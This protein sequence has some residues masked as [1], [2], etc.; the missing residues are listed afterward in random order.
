LYSV[1]FQARVKLSHHIISCGIISDFY[2]ADLLLNVLVEEFGKLVSYLMKSKQI[3]S[4]VLFVQSV[5]CLYQT[6]RLSLSLL[7]CIR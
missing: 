5:Y 6:L 3:L 1:V 2:N 4:G 7:W